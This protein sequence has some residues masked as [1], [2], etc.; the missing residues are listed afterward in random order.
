MPRK[1]WKRKI[2]AAAPMTEFFVLT[3]RRIEHMIK[4]NE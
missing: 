4:Q 3:A 1:T 2:I